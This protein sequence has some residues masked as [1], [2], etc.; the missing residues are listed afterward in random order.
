MARP[1]KPLCMPHLK[2]DSRLDSRISKGKQQHLQARAI[3]AKAAEPQILDS[4]QAASVP[5]LANL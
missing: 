3:H 4:A 1:A 5:K 2:S